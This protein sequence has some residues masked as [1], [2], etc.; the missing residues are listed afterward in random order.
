MGTCE[1]DSWH[2]SNPAMTAEGRAALGAVGVP[3]APSTPSLPPLPHSPPHSTES[4]L[5]PYLSNTLE[6]VYGSFLW[7]WLFK[8][9]KGSQRRTMINPN[10]RLLGGLPGPRD[11]ANGPRNADS[12]LLCLRPSMMGVGG[13]DGG[14]P[15]AARVTRGWVHSWWG[16]QSESEASRKTIQQFCSET[17][18]LSDCEEMPS[19]AAEPL[20]PHSELSSDWR[21]IML[22]GMLM[23]HGKS[24]SATLF[25]VY[26]SVPWPLSCAALGKLLPFSE[27]Q[28]SPLYIQDSN[29]NYIISASIQLGLRSNQL[30]HAK[31]LKQC[32]AQGMHSINT[33]CFISSVISV[34]KY[35]F[36]WLGSLLAP[37]H[38]PTW[39]FSLCI[40]MPY[41]STPSSYKCLL[42]R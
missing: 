4:R 12:C 7:P 42:T 24:T 23:W 29:S 26:I 15:P 3:A 6:N 20:W 40:Y 35:I 18:M 2:V 21:H 32:L 31:C 8:K 36:L 34:Q 25:W 16:S 27:S 9:K 30:S 14:R 19:R 11:P 37:A 17:Q 22:L 38:A 33:H 28:F 10:E 41:P 13:E 5:Q 39:A 1:K